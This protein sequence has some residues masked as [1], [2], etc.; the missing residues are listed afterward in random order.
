MQS[1][2]LNKL[3]SAEG[4]DMVRADRLAPH[5][6]GHDE[7]LRKA[8]RHALLVHEDYTGNE[9]RHQ[10]RSILS[11]NGQRLTPMVAGGD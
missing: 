1:G 9:V 2:I 8:G 5:D 3:A 4:C 6:S 7:F 11:N 10:N